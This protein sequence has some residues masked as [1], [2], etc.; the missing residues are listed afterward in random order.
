LSILP[1]S[2]EPSRRVSKHSPE[3]A[4]AIKISDDLVAEITIWIT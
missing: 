4:A 2:A 1:G 3:S